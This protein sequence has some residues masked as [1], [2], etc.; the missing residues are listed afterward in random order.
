MT[1][2]SVDLAWILE[3]AR[4]AG[5][6]DPAPEDYGLPVAAVARHAAVLA[7]REVY[8]GPFVRAAALCQTL[9]RISWL[10]RSNMTVAVAVAHGY[11]TACGI[12]TKLGRA[13]ITAL[14][15]ELRKDTCTVPDIAAVLR[16][17][18]E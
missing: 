2:P 10:E 15:T 12:D 7:G 3:V 16:T 11:L 6:R 1:H 13:E 4:E 14:V 9:G 8:S 5:E 18:T 17:W